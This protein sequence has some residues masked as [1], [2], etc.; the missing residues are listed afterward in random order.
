MSEE[1]I[2]VK[3]EDIVNA[4]EVNVE[5]VIEHVLEKTITITMEEKVDVEYIKVDTVV[6]DV[7]KETHVIEV[8]GRRIGWIR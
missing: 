8:V 7:L 3:K 6:E 2:T 4:D 5:D 1:V